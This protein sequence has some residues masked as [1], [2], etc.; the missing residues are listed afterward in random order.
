MKAILDFARWSGQRYCGICL[1][2]PDSNAGTIGKAQTR[3]AL[4]TVKEKSGRQANLRKVYNQRH[5]LVMLLPFAVWCII[6]CYL[7]LWGWLM[8]FQNYSPARGLWGSPWVGLKHFES[9]IR[10]FQFLPIIRNTVVI[11]L[12]NIF[13]TMVASILLA[14]MLNELRNIRYKRTIQT[15]TYLPHF[16]SYVVVGN[17]FMTMLS[18]NNGL[19]NELLV[20]M[21]LIQKPI[22][23][24]S[25]PRS[26]W[27]LLSG[28]NIWKEAG[29]DAIIYLAAI[30]SISA[31]LYEAAHVDGA[32]RF[33]RMWHITLPGIRPTIIVLLVLS[34]G[35]VLSAGFEPSYILGNP[36]VSDYSEVI[37]TY[38]Y[39]MGLRNTMF[40][41]ATAVGM[42]RIL[43]SFLVVVLA[44]SFARRIGERGI[45]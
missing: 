36:M 1:P 9:F 8:A 26:F 29:W 23:F 39:T 42:F 44:N 11:S 14:L 31:E 33:R 37:D 18:P 25:L 16:I 45:F 5:L 41:Y 13:G 4:L 32:G 10:D 21:G 34:A 27:Y 7:P 24:F 38:V 6:F 17:I 12:L 15:I 28:I 43:I 35:G 30:S 19:I 3:S 40:S 20:R 2:G 22:F